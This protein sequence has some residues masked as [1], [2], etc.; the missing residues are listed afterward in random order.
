MSSLY[1]H[2]C[3]STL[4]M[5]FIA[6]SMMTAQAEPST[7]EK[8][9]LL[10]PGIQFDT[11]VRL[12]GALN[13]NYSEDDPDPFSL[14]PGLSFQGV[15]PLYSWLESRAEL[16]VLGTLPM[17]DR[18]SVSSLRTGIRIH[19]PDSTRAY[20]QMNLGLERVKYALLRGI[21]YDELYYKSYARFT[22]RAQVGFVVDLTSSVTLD[23]GIDLTMEGISLESMTGLG[24]NLGVLCRL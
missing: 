12:Y 22:S 13:P 20:L 11:V 8:E 10:R 6:S 14:L 3:T 16:S 21:D 9:I 24:L 19:N 15:Y 1:K 17:I 23:L 4:I 5:I 7:P 18:P 2:L